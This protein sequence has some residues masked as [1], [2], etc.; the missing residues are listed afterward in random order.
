MK[1]LDSKHYC[2]VKCI[3]CDNDGEN[4]SSKKACKKERLGV[5]LE[6]TA[7]WT[8][9]QNESVERE[10]AKLYIQVRAM[11]S[12]GKFIIASKLA[13]GRSSTSCYST[14]NQSEL[15]VHHLIPSDHVL[16]TNSTVMMMIMTMIWTKTI[17][18][19][20]WVLW[21]TN[22]ETTNLIIKVLIMMCHKSLLWI[23]KGVEESEG[24][25]RYETNINSK[26]LQ[27]RKIWK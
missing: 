25:P 21:F 20:L 5:F 11:L 13:L 23:L 19:N 26:V 2:K 14:T 7:P 8:P 6:Y 16:T 15:N 27:P 12:D 4:I 18:F 9:Q 3:S 22:M 1:E 17:I 24:N 10:F